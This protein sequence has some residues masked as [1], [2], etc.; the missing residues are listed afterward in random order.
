M[1]LIT[2]GTIIGLLVLLGIGVPV[3]FSL[4]I[5]GALGLL[6]IAGIDTL[7]G[8][9]VTAPLSTTESYE[10]ITIPMFLLMAEFVIIS[11]VA[12]S[13]FN[14]AAIWIGKVRGGL[15]IATA[16]AGAAFGAISGSSTASAATL[17]ATTI[18]EMI[19]QGY[20]PKLACGLVAIS[21]TLA[22][23]IPPSIALIL[24]GIIA[25]VSIGKLLIAGLIPGL[26][27]MVTIIFTIYV[28]MA[29]N[30]ASIPRGQSYSWRSKLAAIR[31]AGPMM[32]LFMAVTG[33]IYTGVA[34]PTEAS[35][36]GAFGAFALAAVSGRLNVKGLFTAATRA[37]GTTCMILMIII[38][39]KIFGYFL[40]LT[41]TTQ[42][43]VAIVSA[44][45]ASPYIIVAVILLVF[46]ALGFIMDQVAILLLMVPITLP[47]V[48][49][50]GFDPIW[51][52]VMVILV[53][54]IGMLTP[55]VGLNVYVVGRFSK[56]PLDLIFSGV[57]PHVFAHLVLITIL[58]FTPQVI[59]WLPGRM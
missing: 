24:Y 14:A 22:M 34:T 48:L 17:S 13:L 30:P 27:V 8:I 53:A 56:Y 45:D 40:T 38:G 12:N 55:P 39:A 20:E 51:F 7:L 19:K 28:L 44:L 54:E 32:L 49:S 50:L 23:L 35:G 1:I 33:I 5:A 18:P 2:I 47:I 59:L 21:G 10:L 3:G 9:L 52:G 42:R 16:I 15:A 25:E 57:W 31:I 41:Q 43:L 37:A 46:L 29:L 11:G 26:M 4:A 6:G 36:I 58:F